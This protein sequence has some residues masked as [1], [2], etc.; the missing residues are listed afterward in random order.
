MTVQ[1]H[2]GHIAQLFQPLHQLTLF[3]NQIKIL[4]M[5]LLRRVG[6]H[7]ATVAVDDQLHAVEAGIGQIQR[8]HYRRNTHR[9]GQNGDMRAARTEDRDQTGQLLLRYLPQHHR[10]QFLADQNGIVG[11]HQLLPTDLLQVGQDAAADILHICRP[12]TQVRVVHQLEAGDMRADHL[13]QRPLSPLASADDVGHLVTQRGII[14]HHQVDIKQRQFFRPQLRRQ[15]AGQLLHVITHAV[16]GAA[17]QRNLGIDILNLLVRDRFQISRRQNHYGMT[18]GYARRA[19]YT[20]KAGVLDHLA[21]PPQPADGTGGF[22]VG[23]D[24][25]QLRTH[26][27][28][29]GLFALIEL[30]ALLLLDHQYAHHP[31]V[32]NNRHTQEG[33]IALFASLGKVAETGVRCR[34]FEVDRLLTGTDVTDQTL[35]GAQGNGTD[36]ILVETFGRHQHVATDFGI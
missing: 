28:Q 8:P 29:E 10:R 20:I 11:E 33:G 14:E 16:L 5:Q 25:G 31:A 23:N 15:L 27:N 35:A 32:V 18:D 7:F 4:A 17:E 24:S 22:R 36:G 12:L 2:T 3:A 6:I 26:G 13:T 30:A 34:I 1:R 19:G 21:A 9:P